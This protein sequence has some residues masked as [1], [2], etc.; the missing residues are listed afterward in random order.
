[1]FEFELQKGSKKFDCPACSQKTFVRYVRRT[2]GEYL[3]FDV[4]RCD[5]ESSCGYHYKPKQFL[6]ENPQAE[7]E[8]IGHYKKGKNL[9]KPEILQYKFSTKTDFIPNDVFLR[10]LTGFEQNAFVQFLSNLFADDLQAVRQAVKDYFIGSTKD[11][12]TIFWQ[13]DQ[14]RRIRTGK[15]IAYDLTNGKRRKD[16]SPNWIHAEMKRRGFLKADFNLKQCF[17]GE[18]LLQIEKSKPIAI[19]EAEKTAVIASICFPEM[20]W[21]A[22]GAKGYLTD[23]R[24]RIL[25]G[26]KV[27]LYPDA[28]AYTFWQEKTAQAQRNGLDVR[29]SKL[30]ETHSTE[31]EKKEGF[32]LAD[33]LIGEQTAINEYNNFADS[34]NAKVDEVL[35]SEQMQ[36]EFQTIIDEQ[37][38]ILIIGG[39]LAE[40]QAETF[41][42][43]NDNLRQTV[44][45]LSIS[46]K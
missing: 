15:I 31:F 46:I 44:L 35:R 23:E 17:F 12:K 37:K 19:V 28:D 10:T 2:N 41:V 20:V 38:S 43:N 5:R 45:N 26:K 27:L 9:R 25:E 3:S 32:D 4:G 14:N 7:I 21:L 1:M 6:L 30:I 16:I 13:I 39:G 22:V 11:G 8:Q 29:I 33:Y 18:H 36:E 34:Y 40:A 24:L 42:C